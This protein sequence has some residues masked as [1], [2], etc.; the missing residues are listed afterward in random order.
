MAASKRLKGVE[1]TEAIRIYV[2]PDSRG[3]DGAMWRIKSPLSTK[4]RFE[5]KYPEGCWAQN[6]KDLIEAI[7]EI[8]QWKLKPRKKRVASL[9]S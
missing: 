7:A 3:E 1:E 5:R 2:T 8:T 4:A 9:A 6:R